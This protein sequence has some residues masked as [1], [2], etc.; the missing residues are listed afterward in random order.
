M[1]AYASEFIAR[2]VSRFVVGQEE[3]IRQIALAICENFESFALGERKKRHNVLLVGPTGSGKTEIARVISKILDIPFIRV[4]MSDYTLTG[5]RGRDPQEIVT[6]DFK[7]KLSRENCEKIRRLRRKFLTRLEAVEIL[8]QMKFSSLEY[9]VGLAY[10]GATVFLDKEKAIE[11]IVSKFGNSDKTIKAVKEAEYLV[12][13]L[14]K[15]AKDFIN[16]QADNCNCKDTPFGVIFVDEIDKI[17]IN[18]RNDG[19]SFYRH[20]QEFMLTMVEGAVVSHNKT[21]I[22][23]SHITFIFAG[24]FSQF[25]PEEFIP[26]FKGRLDIKARVRKL[27]VEDYIKIAQKQ[28]FRIPEGFE[29]FLVKVHPSALVEVAKVCE[30]MNDEEY[31]G[32][33]RIIE[34]MSR[35]NESL[36]RE[37]D[38]A[39]SLERENIKAFPISLDADFVRASIYGQNSLRS[40]SGSVSTEIDLSSILEFPLKESDRSKIN[41]LVEEF[42]FKKVVQHYKTLLQEEGLTLKVFSNS[43]LIRNSEGKSVFEYLVKE[44]FIKVV[45]FDVFKVLKEKLGKETLERFKEH[46]KIIGSSD[47]DVPDDWKEVLES[48]NELFGDTEF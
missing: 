3:A 19:A 40:E 41:K 4:T 46:L 12:T 35:V 36:K 13:Q 27:T 20:L 16:H 45:T 29:N 22:D 15:T 37:I 44:G 7:S 32:A 21:K 42:L 1:L 26:E 24:A 34:I 23:T 17:L 28:G 18:E 38:I 30:E 6:T 8:R 48:L 2:E 43:L 39:I 9:I 10:A 31:L 5:Y 25:S 14:E 11:G 47:I 33:R